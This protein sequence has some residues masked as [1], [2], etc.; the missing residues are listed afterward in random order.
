MEE[1]EKNEQQCDDKVW[2]LEEFVVAITR[3]N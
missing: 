3:L 2:R 1:E